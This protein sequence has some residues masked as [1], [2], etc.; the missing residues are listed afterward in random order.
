VTGDSL[1]QVE[2]LEPG[3]DAKMRKIASQNGKDCG[4]VNMGRD[5][6][7]SMWIAHV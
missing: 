2:I 3:D 6:W 1:K 5:G 7:E 4:G